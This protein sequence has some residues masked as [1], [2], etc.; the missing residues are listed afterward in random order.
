MSATSDF[1]DFGDLPPPPRRC[2]ASAVLFTVIA[3][4]F[5]AS[6]LLAAVGLWLVPGSD[7]SAELMLIKLAMT[8][9]FGLGGYSFVQAARTRCSVA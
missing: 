1:Q 5:G 3:F 4:A 7:W 8:G 6:L 9:L 2:G